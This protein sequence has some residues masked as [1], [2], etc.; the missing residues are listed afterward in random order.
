M[1][2]NYVSPTA[3]IGEG[4]KIWHFAVILDEV[5]IGA[6]CSI[7]SHAEI[8][9]GST[10][11]YGS[12]ISHGVFLPNNSKIGLNVFIGPGVVFTDDRYPRVNNPHYKAEPPVVEDGANIGAGAVILPGVTIGKG[13]LIG[14]GAVVTKNVKPGDLVRGPAA[15]SMRLLTCPS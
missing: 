5:V 4:T 6:F 1:I 12:R 11:G 7:G 9:K 2:I 3:E 10:I 15:A 13:A 14:A 8:G